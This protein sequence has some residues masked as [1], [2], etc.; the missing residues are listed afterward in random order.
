MALRARFVETAGDIAADR[1]PAFAQKTY[2]R[3]NICECYDRTAGV[4]RHHPARGQER[5]MQTASAAA[6]D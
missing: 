3:I 2:R 6:H 5:R 4:G 1:N